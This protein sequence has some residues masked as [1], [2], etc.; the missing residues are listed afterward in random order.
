MTIYGSI[1]PKA[2]SIA[3]WANRTNLTS[4]AKHRLKTLDWHKAHGNNIS[5]TS[6]HFG[7]SRITVRKWM[8]RFKEKGMLGLNDLSRRPN[9][10]RKPETSRDV[11]LRT[12]S[13]R[14]KYPAWSKYKIKALLNKEDMN[15][16]AST[17][18]RI[19]KRYDLIDKKVSLRRKKSALKPKARFPKGFKIANPGDMVQ[20]DTKYIMLPGGH[21]LY[22]FTAIDVLTKIRTLEV[23]PSE[24]S[25][26]GKKFIDECIKQF[27]F[28]I[29][30][31]QTD[32]GSPF[33]KEFDKHCKEKDIPHYFTY[34]RHPK[35]NSY[36]E[37]SHGSDQTEFYRFGN[38]CSILEEMKKRINNW[39]DIWNNIRPH[40][41][42]N[43]LTPK[44]YF[45]KWQN[46]HLPTRDVI[47]LQT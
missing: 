32:N 22:Q 25:R 24:S 42:L 45:I 36:V 14:R 46:G 33:L 11:V 31:I 38:K 19:F 5:L 40:E 43:Q 16:S 7:L 17:I 26:N 41:S 23:Y 2:A 34:P 13:L 27:P 28:E 8:E 21:R 3:S 29:K 9:N 39:Q 1:F 18:G 12:V 35:Q 30:A 10:L 47:T 4:E 44:E 6:R 37:R 15:V 20:M